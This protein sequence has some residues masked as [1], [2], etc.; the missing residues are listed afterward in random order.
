MI[1]NQ[2]R[3]ENGEFAS[4]FPSTPHTPGLTHS[5]TDTETSSPPST[6]RQY[7]SAL[8]AI[9]TQ[10]MTAAMADMRDD[11]REA[12]RCFDKE[13]GYSDEDPIERHVK[14]YLTPPKAQ[15]LHVRDIGSK[16]QVAELQ[17]QLEVEEVLI[18]PQKALDDSTSM[19]MESDLDNPPC[20]RPGLIQFQRTHSGT[21]RSLPTFGMLRADSS[22]EITSGTSGTSGTSTPFGDG[23][24]TPGSAFSEASFEVMKPEDVMSLY[25][26]RYQHQ[27]PHQHSHQLQSFPGISSSSSLDVHVTAPGRI[28]TL[29]TFS[30]TST[31]TDTTIPAHTGTFSKP[32]RPAMGRPRSRPNPY[33]RERDTGDPT[34]LTPGDEGEEWLNGRTVSEQMIA[35]AGLISQRGRANR[36]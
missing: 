6:L 4:P 23:M 12:E 29:S 9:M 27:H 34:K 15:M 13:F 7:S 5:P 1:S 26:Y 8:K 17:R 21:R 22:G 16:Y 2:S 28:S 11:T 24:D 3:R 35:Q 18:H 10:G 19:D 20:F 32:V 31:A 36:M 14:L 25:G 33:A 30:T